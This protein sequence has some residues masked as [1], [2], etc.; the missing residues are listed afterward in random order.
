MTDRS[1]PPPMPGRASPGGLPVGAVSAYAGPLAPEQGMGVAPIE[2]SGWMLCD[3]RSLAA[4]LYPEL[5]AVLGTLYGG[6][7][8]TFH[9]PDYRGTFLR[10]ADLGSGNDPDAAVRTTA[11]GGTAAGVGSTQASALQDHGHGYEAVVSQSGGETGAAPG[12]Q[13]LQSPEITGRPVSA[14]GSQQPVRT[15]QRETR[16]ANI[17]VNYIIK[18]T[19]F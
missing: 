11:N 14:P 5:Y 7:D 2:A 4:A 9:I 19:S 6:S 3:G 15:S 16:P 17:A 10:G 18:F 12:G 13:M 8:G 1:F